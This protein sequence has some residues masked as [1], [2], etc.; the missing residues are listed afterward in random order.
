MGITNIRVDLEFVEREIAKHLVGKEG[1]KIVLIDQDFRS[2]HQDVE[3]IDIRTQNID[4][5]S[6]QPPAHVLYAADQDDLGLPFI[7][8]LIEHNIKFFPAFTSWAARYV[9]TDRHARSAIESEYLFQAAAGFA[10]SIWMKAI[11]ATAT[12]KIS[13]KLSAELVASMVPMSRLGALEEV[14]EALP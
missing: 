3:I 10:N 1:R 6:G 9:H 8:W 14:P 7:L 2:A 13:A 11:R 4:A 12:T 5:I